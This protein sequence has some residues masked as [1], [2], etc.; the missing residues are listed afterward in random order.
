MGE[1]LQTLDDLMNTL[2]DKY[3]L[4]QVKYTPEVFQKPENIQPEFTYVPGKL[5]IS[6]ETDHIQV[7]DNLPKLKVHVFNP[8]NYLT[9]REYKQLHKVAVYS[10]VHSSDIV[11]ANLTHDETFNFICEFVEFNDH[12][13]C[14]NRNRRKTV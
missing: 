10:A 2:K 13:I 4:I 12:G 5:D 9:A 6:Y 1:E 14:S 3:N 11:T 8:H 7:I